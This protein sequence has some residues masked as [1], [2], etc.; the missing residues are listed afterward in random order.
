MG[1]LITEIDGDAIEFLLRSDT[2]RAS[3]RRA[4]PF[5]HRPARR[6]TIILE[7]VP[8]AS[9]VTDQFG[10]TQSVGLLGIKR[11]VRNI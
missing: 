10:G 9:E 4:F 1:D 3:E 8:D 11:N 2:H 7:A 6:Q 5:H